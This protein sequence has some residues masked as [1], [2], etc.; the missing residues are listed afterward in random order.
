[1]KKRKPK[2]CA[3]S[4][5]VWLLLS[6]A[7]ARRTCPRARAGTSDLERAVAR[8]AASTVA[9]AAG[10]DAEHV[11]LYEDPAKRKVR[12]LIPVV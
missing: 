10:R 7:H 9:G 8:L 2:G 6:S 11:V 4:G 5:P 12:G 1:M 3:F